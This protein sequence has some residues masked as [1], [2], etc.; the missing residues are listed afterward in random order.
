[1][2]LGDICLF[3]SL[4]WAP[5]TAAA[6]GGLGRGFTALQLEATMLGVWLQLY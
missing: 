1:M 2:L 6:R 3:P 5:S 4:C